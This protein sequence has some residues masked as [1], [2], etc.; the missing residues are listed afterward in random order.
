MK[1]RRKN[2]E[3]SHKN[4]ANYNGNNVYD[5]RWNALV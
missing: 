5:A 4:R 2:N 3:K 1:K